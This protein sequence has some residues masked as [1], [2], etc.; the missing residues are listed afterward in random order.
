MEKKGREMPRT[1]GGVPLAIVVL[2][3][4]LANRHTLNEWE[5]VHHSLDWYLRGKASIYKTKE[6]NKCLL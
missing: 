5:R 6:F 4:L 2:G 1:C 3:G